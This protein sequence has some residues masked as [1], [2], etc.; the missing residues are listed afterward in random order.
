MGRCEAFSL[1]LSLSLFPLRGT[2]KLSLAVLI[3]IRCT[4]FQAGE[5][6]KARHFTCGRLR[7]SKNARG[8]CNRTSCEGA[9]R[10]L[11]LSEHI[12][13]KI[14]SGEF[15]LLR[16]NCDFETVMT[17]VFAQNFAT[18]IA[19]QDKFQWARSIFSNCFHCVHHAVYEVGLFVWV[20]PIYSFM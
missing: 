12:L 15:F 18:L 3:R 16:L 5:R 7:Q 14:R 1:S 8:K 2:R 4:W 17:L 6:S 11:A 20:P 9:H 13:K 10:W 19:A